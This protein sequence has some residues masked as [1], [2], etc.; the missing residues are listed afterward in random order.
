MQ[1][2]TAMTGHGGWPM[3]VVLDHDGNPFFA[4]TYFPDRARGGMPAFRQVLEAVN[5][6]V[7]GT[8][9]DDVRRVATDLREH[10]QRSVA[11]ASTVS[12]PLDAAVLDAAV[13][14]LS[15]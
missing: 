9:P 11:S 13:T 14:R 5:G 3:T 7:D 15:D 8:R 10:L 4:G 6:R 12:A 1:A 2:T